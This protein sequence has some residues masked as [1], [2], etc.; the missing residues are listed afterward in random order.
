MSLAKSCVSMNARASRLKDCNKELALILELGDF[1]VTLPGNRKML[2]GAIS[3]ILEYFQFDSGRVYLVEGSGQTLVLAGSRGIDIEGLEEMRLTEGFSG[4]AVR[5]GSF[6]VQHVSELE[7]KRRMELLARQGCETVICVP[8][9]V[10]DECLG[11]MNFT[12]SRDIQLEQ[13]EIDLL[14]A[15]ANQV[16]LAV[17]HWKLYEDQKKKERMSEFMIYS[18]SHDIRSPAVG[19]HGLARL[20]LKQYGSFLDDKVRLYCAQIMSATGDIVALVEDV[21]SYVSTQ[22][23]ALDIEAVDLKEVI[24]TVRCSYSRSLD[25]RHIRWLESEWI[26]TVKVDRLAITRILQNLVDNALKYGG[27]RLSEIRVDY[28]EDERFHILS[29]SDDGVGIEEEDSEEIFELF[30]RVATS[31]GTKGTGLGLPIIREMARRHGGKVWLQSEPR[32]GTKF[33]VSIPKDLEG[34]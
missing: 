33:F 6:L 5:T 11:V 28:E 23:P 17:S 14:I 27:D 7:G 30:T 13:G 29:V 12:A 22:K 20:L 16:A 26:P 18:A 19:A 4:K 34:S 3:I 25:A 15:A 2:E 9:T 32:G 1:L 10:R 31:R 8:L 21:M 24:A